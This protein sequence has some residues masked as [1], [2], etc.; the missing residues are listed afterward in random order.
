MV[1]AQSRVSPRQPPPAALHMSGGQQQQEV[2][3]GTGLP[4]PTPPI[5]WR[6][7]MNRATHLRCSWRVIRGT[8]QITPKGTVALLD[9]S[10]ER[11]SSCSYL[12]EN[13]KLTWGALSDIAM[14]PAAHVEKGS[15]RGTPTH[16]PH[17]V[18]LCTE[19]GVVQ[20]GRCVK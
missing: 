16:W 13:L 15:P 14:P 7:V 11:C 17:P 19:R 2:L 9:W 8:C 4:V 6:D 3:R 12:P 1:S 10:R 18:S 20:T 5:L